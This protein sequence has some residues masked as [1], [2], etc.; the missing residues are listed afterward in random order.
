M[1]LEKLGDTEIEQNVN[2]K[3]CWFSNF[4][5]IFDFDKQEGF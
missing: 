1:N 4:Y 2:L 5:P 3:R